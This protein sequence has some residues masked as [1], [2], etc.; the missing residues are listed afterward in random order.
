MLDAEVDGGEEGVD[1]GGCEEA[2]DELP[3]DSHVVVVVCCRLYIHVIVWDG[4]KMR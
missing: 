3:G 4:K 2:E 1:D